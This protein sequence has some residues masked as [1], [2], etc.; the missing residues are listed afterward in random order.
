[1]ETAAV[2]LLSSLLV[3]FVQ[4]GLAGLGSNGDDA[5]P[6]VNRTG[7]AVSPMA[8][9]IVT[10]VIPANRSATDEA[11]E[12]LDARL[13]T[14]ENRQRSSEIVIKNNRFGEREL[15][16]ADNYMHYLQRQKERGVIGLDDRKFANITQQPYSKVNLIYKSIL[17]DTQFLFWSVFVC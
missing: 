1:M 10:L 11:A 7:V 12:E 9:P 17:I 13:I 5:S 6:F 2:L 4:T 3:G 14:V 15:E 16:A 8:E